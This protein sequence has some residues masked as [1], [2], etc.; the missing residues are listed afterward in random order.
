MVG[1]PQQQLAPIGQLGLQRRVLRLGYIPEAQLAGLYAA[2]TAVVYPSRYEG[3]GLPIVEGLAAGVP[4]VASDLPVFREVGGDEVVLFDPV[5]SASIA[6]ALECA[7]SLDSGQA[8]RER[9]RDQ[10]R[11]FDWRASAEIVARRLQEAS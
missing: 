3:F 10:S 9:R 2:A 1:M 4:V 11:K 7:L 6:S 5:D 8:A